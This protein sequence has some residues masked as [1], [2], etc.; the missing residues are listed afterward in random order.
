M[1]QKVVDDGWITRAEAA[2]I[3][4]VHYNT[5]RTLENEG[6]VRR[7]RVEER[8]AVLVNREDIERYAR[9]RERRVLGN[10]SDATSPTLASVMRVVL[11]LQSRVLE[12]EARLRNLSEE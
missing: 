3:A 6:R 4:N 12:L 10:V 2:R 7:R 8:S 5:I 9:E 11:D 1:P